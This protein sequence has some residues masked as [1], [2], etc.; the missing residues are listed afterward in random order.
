MTFSTL[1]RSRLLNTLGLVGLT[2]SLV[3]GVVGWI[4]AD[5]LGSA[6]SDTV[7]P[8][9]AATGDLAA[10]V[11]A[12]ETLVVRTQEALESIENAARAAGRSLLSLDEVLG[13]TASLAE[14]DVA[15]SLDGALESFPALISTSR[16]IHAAMTTLSFVGV[17]YDPD[18]PLDRSLAQLRDSLT[19]IPEQVRTQAA[20]LD[21]I[22][23]DLEVI[24]GDTGRLAAVLL[25]TRLEMM[26]IE[27]TISDAADNALLI[28]EQVEDAEAELGSLEPL[29]KVVAVAVAVALAAASATPMVIARTYR[30][31]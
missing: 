8:V 13:E 17:D 25:D 21:S 2:A 4:I 14:T 6:I 27:R 15:G 29:S 30:E 12:S 9:A 10:T 28:A 31:D 22:R 26:A 16:V 7:T 11:Q 24:S 1:E 20:L 3:V 23:S 19:P 5:R 18:E